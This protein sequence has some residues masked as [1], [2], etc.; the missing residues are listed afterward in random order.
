MIKKETMDT[1]NRVM[2]FCTI[3]RPINDSIA[4]LYAGCGLRVTGFKFRVSSS[5]FRVT[6]YE[7]RVADSR[8]KVESRFNLQTL[9]N[10]III[11]FDLFKDS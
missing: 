7:L 1:K 10:V 9:Q 3:L 6:S 11:A 4:N 5:E 8:F 2:I